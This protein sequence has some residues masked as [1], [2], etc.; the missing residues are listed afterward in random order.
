MRTFRW[1][2]AL[3]TITFTVKAQ[4]NP[5]AIQIARDRWGVPHI[6]AKTDPEVA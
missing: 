6:F 1:L 2:V 3:I 4:I 5:D